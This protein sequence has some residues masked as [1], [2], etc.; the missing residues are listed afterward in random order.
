MNSILKNLQDPKSFQTYI[1]EYMK[2]ST[3][4]AEWKNELK[5]VE[6]CAA[7]V[8]QANMATYAAAMVGSVVAKNAERPLHTMPDWGQLTGSIGRIADEWELDN[9]Y[10]DQMHLLE[11]KYNDMSGRGG[12]T[13][14]QLNAKY[15]ELIKYSFKPFELAV[16]APHKRIDMLYFEGLFKGTQTVSRTNNSKANVSYTFNLGVK[17]LSATTNW[18]EVNATPI[19]DIK[20]LKDEA[21]KKG[22]KILRLRMSENTFFAM[23]KAKEIKDTFRLNLGQITINP[24]APMISVDQMNIYLRS[25]L[26]PTIQIDEDKFVELPDKTVFN[27]IPDNRVVAMCA[28]KV[29]V[30]KCAECLEAIDPVDGV[31]YS[32]Y[33]NNLIGYWRDKKGYHLTNEMWMQ[34]VFDGIEDFFILKVDA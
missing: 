25:I 16:I 4:K 34:P 7:K 1:D 8:Y 29:A 21:R 20:K 26:L 27:L 31:S 5:P 18:G 22:R 3:Y 24:T 33:D 9:D 17:Q 11:G 10:L 2:T 12:Y 30:P 15:D 32:T 19:E 28:D 23:C 13:Q 6:Y 14:S